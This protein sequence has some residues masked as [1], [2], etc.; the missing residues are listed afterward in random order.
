MWCCKS[1]ENLLATAGEKGM[2]IV[3]I[4]DGEYRCFYLQARPLE[5]DV[6]D[7]YSKI[8]PLTGKTDWPELEG[9]NGRL[10]SY[11]TIINLMLTY[12]PRCGA[13]LDRVI[14]KNCNEFDALCEK[15]PLEITELKMPP[16]WGEVAL[17]HIK[18]T[19]QSFYKRFLD[20]LRKW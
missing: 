15:I 4:R 10:V 5:R 8:N 19:K 12:C 6:W 18:G 1:F 11:A 17:E 2:S 16:R 14:K 9:D 3:P 20:L 7:K 13:R